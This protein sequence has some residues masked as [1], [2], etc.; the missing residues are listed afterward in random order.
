[1]LVNL[2]YRCEERAVKIIQ[3]INRPIMHIGVSVVLN[4]EQYI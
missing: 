1:M 3:H 2:V 4:S